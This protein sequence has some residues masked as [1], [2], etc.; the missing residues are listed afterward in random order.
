MNAQH[1]T[2]EPIFTAQGLGTITVLLLL[3]ACE[4]TAAG[5]V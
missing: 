4:L 1:T 2:R 5:W 3:L